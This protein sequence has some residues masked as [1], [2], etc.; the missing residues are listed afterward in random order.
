MDNWLTFTGGL[1]IGIEFVEWI[2]AICFLILSPFWWLVRHSKDRSLALRLLAWMLG[3]T[4]FVVLVPLVILSLAATT[5]AR[6]INN[7]L[8]RLL[9][10]ATVAEMQRFT[11]TI[12][13]LLRSASRGMLEEIGED[14]VRQA[15]GVRKVPFLGVTGLFL[16]VAGFGFALASS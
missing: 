13:F 1:L 9:L 11:N 6:A 7:G 14:Q 2:G 16:V 4:V 15:L 3:V 12:N 8:N 5:L 10:M